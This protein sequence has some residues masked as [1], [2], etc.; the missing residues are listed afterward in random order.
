MPWTVTVRAGGRVRRERHAE[1]TA[2]LDAVEAAGRA[3]ERGPG[4]RAIDIKTRRF[5]PV[6]LVAARI[7]LSGPSRLLPDVRAGVD[8]RGDGSVEAWAGR[9]N[10]RVLEPE[11]GET[12]YAALRRAVTS[13]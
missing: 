13:A 10:R 12:A 9:V 1:L 7:E 6:Q 8:V 11:A 4:R 5:E 3:V 2:A